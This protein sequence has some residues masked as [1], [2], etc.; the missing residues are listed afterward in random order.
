MT[1]KTISVIVIFLTLVFYNPKM[2]NN[3]YMSTLGRLILITII[4]LFSIQNATLGL[5]VALIVIS[6]SNQYGS[7]TESSIIEGLDNI[8]EDNIETTGSLPVLTK[9]E[10]E[11]RDALK[12]KISDLKENSD[13]TA[14]VDKETIKDT[15]R[16]KD[17]NTI[18]V[19]PNIM[20]NE[21]VS[22][23]QPNMDGFSRYS[24]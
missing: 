8:G 10:S 3:M 1:I 21:E 19:D 13:I 14:G 24:L 22:A 15:I 23:H 16:A 20:K 12:H 2:L 18:N 6:A 17:S 4:I 5:L 11:R 7:F 9:S